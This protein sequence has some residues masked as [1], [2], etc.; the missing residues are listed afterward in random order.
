MTTTTTT[1]T[2][3]ET[4]REQWR[5][6][7]EQRTAELSRPHGWLSL[8]GLHWLTGGPEAVADLPGTW[9]SVDGGVELTASTADGV[10]LDG[11]PVDGTV[12]VDTVEGAPGVLVE[13]G[14]RR[15]EVMQRSGLH[16]LRVRDPQAP[17][18]AAFTGV[19][20]FDFDERYVLDAEFVPYA[21]SREVVVG[22]V[23]EGLRHHHDA[24]GT[25]RFDLDG[26][27]ELVVF[28]DGKA[29]FTDATSGVTTTGTT[30]SVPVPTDPGPVVLD[31]NLAQNL[32][33]AFTDHATC[34]LPPAENRL[35]VAVAAGEKDPR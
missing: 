9:A 26:P 30:R 27:Q 28:A 32:P 14:D 33:C 3:I 16:A 6:W 2:T 4:R 23:V 31:L 24:V 13:L 34:P 12:R 21:Q 7:R 10:V 17:A 11:A 29:L 25:V 20:V 15:V 5:A 19:P 18:R 8:T 35:T 22:A 1:T